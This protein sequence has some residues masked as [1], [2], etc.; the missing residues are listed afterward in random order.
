[1]PFQDDFAEKRI[2]TYP[3]TPF[4]PS[5]APAATEGRKCVNPCQHWFFG[6]LPAVNK[7]GEK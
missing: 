5:A 6:C 2:K 7:I 4:R 1:M 3:Q